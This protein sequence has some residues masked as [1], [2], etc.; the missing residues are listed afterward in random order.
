MTHDSWL[1]KTQSHHN[2]EIWVPQSTKCAFVEL[3]RKHVSNLWRSLKHKAYYVCYASNKVCNFAAQNID[4]YAASMLFPQ[5]GIGALFHAVVEFNPWYHPKQGTNHACLSETGWCFFVF[6]DH[7]STYQSYPI[8]SKPRSGAQSDFDLQHPTIKYPAFRS[9]WH[10][11]W[12]CLTEIQQIYALWA[13][14]EKI[15]LNSTMTVHRVLKAL[16]PSVFLKAVL[17]ATGRKAQCIL[18]NFVKYVKESCGPRSI[19]II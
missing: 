18:W 7:Q 11:S 2:K 4:E 8:L 16:F 5:P 1:S 9:G 15:K 14:W 12:T 10:R 6:N 19:F 17:H 13:R 3:A